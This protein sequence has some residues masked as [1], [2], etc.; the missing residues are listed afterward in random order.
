MP[1]EAERRHLAS[2]TGRGRWMGPLRGELPTP[3]PGLR[4]SDQD[5]QAFPAPLP[6]VQA[7]P[8]QKYSKTSNSFVTLLLVN[9]DN[10]QTTTKLSFS[11]RRNLPP[12]IST[13][14]LHFFF[15]CQPLAYNI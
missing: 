4:E 2:R 3:Q 15:L 1:S 8:G 7:S 5:S 9:T 11:E 14:Y 6:S 13:K 10:L 12:Q